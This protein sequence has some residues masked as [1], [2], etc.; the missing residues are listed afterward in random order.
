M[1]YEYKPTTIPTFEQNQIQIVKESTAIPSELRKL[2]IAQVFPTNVT[3]D[4]AGTLNQINSKNPDRPAAAF[5]ADSTGKIGVYTT[6]RLSETT[7]P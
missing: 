3:P 6:Y 2:R 5:S 4:L 7:S 1:S